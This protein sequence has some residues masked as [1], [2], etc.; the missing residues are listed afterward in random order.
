MTNIIEVLRERGLLED[1]T[2]PELSERVESPCVV[3]AGFD[4]T[5]ESLQVGNL[6]TIMMLAHF[7]RCGHRVIALVGGATGS[8]GDP[9]GKS[10]S[11]RCCLTNKLRP[12]RLEFVRT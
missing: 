1:L 8:I 3:Y 10:G 12:M 6:V 4:P 2:S 9:S 5:A 11:A 7:Q